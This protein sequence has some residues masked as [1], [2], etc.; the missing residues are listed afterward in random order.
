MSH[1][2]GTRWLRVAGS[3]LTIS[4]VIAAT[5]AMRSAVP[6]HAAGQSLVISTN[7][8]D[9]KTM[10]PGH[11]YEFA[12]SAMATNC[13]DSLVT[14]VG[15]DTIHLKPNLA[16]S[17]TTSADG[18]VYTFVL[19]HNVK[20]A[21]GNPMTAADVVFSYLRLKYLNDNPSFLVSGVSGIKAVDPYTV[22]IT[23]GAP[24]ASF[25][26]AMTGTNLAVLDSKLVIAHGGDA[27]PD[28]AKKD[29]AQSFLDT[30]SAGTNAF[31]MTNWTRN[32]QIV[33][34]RNPN[35][36]G[37]KPFFA[38][39]V[40]QHQKNAATQR[41]L[42]QRGAVDGATD[43]NIQEVQSLIHDPSVQ[44]IQG[45][46]LNLVYMGMTTS[47]AISKPLANP[48]VRQAIR[49]AIDYDGILKGLLKGVG[50]RPNS[51]IPVGMLGND[52]ATNNALLIH[53]DLA[54]ARAL[55][56][57]AGYANGFSVTMGYDVGITYDGVSYDPLSAKIQ[58]DLAKVGIK[59][60]LDPE[61]DTVLLTK[62]RAQ[63]LQMILYN[64]GVDYPDPNDYSGPFSPGGGP[65]KRMLFTWDKTLT[66]VVN[67]ADSTTD[68]AK[69]TALYR[70][71]QQTWLA[72]G[73]WIGLVQ[74][75]NI[76]VLSSKVKGYTYSPINP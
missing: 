10:D 37:A 5:P 57:A 33:M 4:A 41:L 74:P 56:K 25:L 26:S 62:Y 16:T 51:M 2:A 45:N 48:R 1:I 11:A 43:I 63:K 32:V 53:T 39:V 68:L 40:F 24:D 75:Q 42:V 8:S 12:S 52:T 35:Y 29:K 7:I 58:N 6:A 71:V 73:P 23:L 76:V 64:W 27:S 15:N 60:T 61:Q 65:A 72:E 19:R 69:R 3:L 55:L 54:K 34:D 47:A 49:Y 13:Y 17:W 66:G 9:G 20:F 14:Y 46:T 67:M 30:Q 28:A 38:K 22:Q 59:V 44:V 18:K 70:T 21:S 31:Q 50:T 36:W